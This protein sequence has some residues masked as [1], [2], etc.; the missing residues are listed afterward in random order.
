[1]TRKNLPE[2]FHCNL[3][4]QTWPEDPG[5][6]VKFF[7]LMM[8]HPFALLDSQN[9]QQLITRHAYNLGERLADILKGGNHG[10]LQ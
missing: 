9:V 3:C 4:S 5:D 2:K 6:G 7:H 8:E 1:M 10:S